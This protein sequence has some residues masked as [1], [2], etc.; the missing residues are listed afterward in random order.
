MLWW[1]E[2]MA[3]LLPMHWSADSCVKGLMLKM[4]YSSGAV[5]SQ[6][7]MLSSEVWMD[8]LGVF[9]VL[10]YKWHLT[11]W[12]HFSLFQKER[13]T[14]GLGRYVRSLLF[15]VIHFLFYFL[16]SCLLFRCCRRWDPMPSLCARICFTMRWGLDL[17]SLGTTKP[18]QWISAG[19]CRNTTTGYNEIGFDGL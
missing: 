8:V 3:T 7:I 11:Q 9:H 10:S 16:I 1:P 13:I 6:R 14:E 17:Q 18:T 5:E 19:D 15:N 2:L 4:A 12:E